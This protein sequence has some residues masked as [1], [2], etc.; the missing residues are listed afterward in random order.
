MYAFLYIIFIDA[1]N[2]KLRTISSTLGEE[3]KQKNKKNKLDQTLFPAQ[4]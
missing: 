1:L 4:N 2:D 3:K